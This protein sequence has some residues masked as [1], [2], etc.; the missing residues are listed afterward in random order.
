MDITNHESIFAALVNRASRYTIRGP[1]RGVDDSLVS[2]ALDET[3]TV[4]TSFLCNNNENN[5]RIALAEQQERNRVLN[6][7]VPKEV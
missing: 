3:G 7:G 2:W 6:L 5:K 1:T 4:D